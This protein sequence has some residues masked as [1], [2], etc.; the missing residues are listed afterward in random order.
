MRA[1]QGIVGC[2]ER[3]GHFGGPPLALPFALIRSSRTV[4]A[5]KAVL[6]Q[7]IPPRG[8]CLENATCP[9]V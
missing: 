8:K 9:C 3:L 6:N 5:V 4:L 1:A 7:S 2:G